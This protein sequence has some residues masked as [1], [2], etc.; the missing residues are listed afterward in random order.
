MR[1]IRKFGLSFHQKRS[2]ITSVVE[3]SV[4]VER[5]D[6]IISLLE[7]ANKQPSILVKIGNGAA[8]GAGILG[9]ISVVDIIKTIASDHNKAIELNPGIMYLYLNRGSAYFDKGTIPGAYRT[10]AQASFCRSVF[11]VPYIPQS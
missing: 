10:Q 8:T 9:L 5:L 7:T 1:N 3:K 11:P 2:I 4:L 6:K